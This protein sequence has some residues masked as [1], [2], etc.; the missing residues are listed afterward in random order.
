MVLFKVASIIGATL[1]I[2][3]GATVAL[4]FGMIAAQTQGVSVD[5]ELAAAYA[6]IGALFG[7]LSWMVKGR[8]E[9]CEKRE[10]TL[11]TADTDKTSTM[12]D[13][14]ATVTKAADVAASAVAASNAAVEE[15]RR[16]GQKLDALLPSVAEV[17][18][19][20][21]VI[22]NMARRVEELPRNK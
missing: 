18:E 13:L 15:S 6:A 8:I 7:L 10:D 11:L 12:R 16:N 1:Q 22:S 19:L 21:T 3:G 20:R 4:F 9:R 5:P 17:R 2:S 14:A